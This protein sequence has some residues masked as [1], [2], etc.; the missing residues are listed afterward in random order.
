L[1]E[2]IVAEIDAEISRLQQARALLTGISAPSKRGPGRPAKTAPLAAVPKKKR[3][4]S[5]E[6]R[7]KMRQAQLKRWAAVKKSAKKSNKE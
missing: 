3:R 5:A 4:L 6:A 7:E 1:L 2:N